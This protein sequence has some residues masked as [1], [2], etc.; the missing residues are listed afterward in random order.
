ME[1]ID[2]NDSLQAIAK[3]KSRKERVVFTNG[4]FD[5]LHIGHSR[6]LTQARALG[7]LLVV[8]LNSDR[9]VRA[10]KGPARP[11][12][13]Q[14]ERRELLLALKAVD[15]VCIFD[16]ETPLKLIQEVRPDILVKGGDWPVEKIVGHE[17]VASIGGRTMSL[18]Y[19]EG[20]STSDI[21]RRIQSGSS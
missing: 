2:N 15:Y 17:F 1:K 21:I 16:E 13:P 18:P 9:S 14:S 3:H 12:V 4:C 19:V 20:N 6:Y 7:D 5:V 8:G 10:L 11:I